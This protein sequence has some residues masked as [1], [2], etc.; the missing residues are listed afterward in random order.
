MI[1]K[2]LNL[3]IGHRVIGDI[4]ANLKGALKPPSKGHMVS[5]TE[6]KEVG[7]LLLTLD[8]Y[9]GTPEVV[10]AFKLAPLL[11]CRPDELRK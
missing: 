8:D 10:A 1:I 9:H 2:Y 6:P 11:F 7:L 3:H 5:L 4:S